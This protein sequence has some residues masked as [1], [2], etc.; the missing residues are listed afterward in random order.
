[1]DTSKIRKNDVPYVNEVVGYLQARNLSVE[2]AGSVLKGNRKY[3]D[4]D[5]LVRGGVTDLANATSGLMGLDVRTEPFPKKSADG[6]EYTV[7]HA[8]GPTKYLNNQ[9][10]ERF[11]ITVGN[12][13]IDVC[14]KVNK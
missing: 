1:M 9:I 5:L 11:N 12:T 8:G 4:I 6:L 3:N 14:L 10:D 2:I 13:K 7:T